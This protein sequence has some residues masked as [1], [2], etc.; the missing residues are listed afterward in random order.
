MGRHDRRTPERTNAEASALNMQVHNDQELKYQPLLRDHSCKMREAT[1]ASHEHKRTP[2]LG[3]PAPKTQKES[4][5]SYII[6]TP[7]LSLNDI[8]TYTTPHVNHQR[9]IGALYTLRSPSFKHRNESCIEINNAPPRNLSSP[10]LLDRF[11]Q[12]LY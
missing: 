6:P 5:F 9:T 3:C 8:K 7:S 12:P 4:Y 1:S 10:Q 11:R 2:L